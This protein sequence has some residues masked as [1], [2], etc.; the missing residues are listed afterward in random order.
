MPKH[1]DSSIPD[2]LEREEK[3]K[4]TF[5]SVSKDL[6]AC[7]SQI[8]DLAAQEDRAYARDP[9]YQ[10]GDRSAN[11]NFI[12]RVRHNQELAQTAHTRIS[13]MKVPSYVP[14]SE[15]VSDRKIFEDRA[16]KRRIKKT[17]THV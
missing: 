2:L 7:Y 13:S 10:R 15:I 1:T 8:L 12:R 9:H 11:A 5:E 16:K 6:F 17:V 14:A 3:L 4:Q